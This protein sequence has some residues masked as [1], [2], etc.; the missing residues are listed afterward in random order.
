MT[1]QYYI[2]NMAQHPELQAGVDSLVQ[3]WQEFMLHDPVADAHFGHLY[4][5]FLDYQTAIC[6]MEGQ[7]VARALCVPIFWE[8]G[9]SLPDTGWQWALQNSVDTYTSREAPNTVCAIEISVHPKLRGTGL[10]TIALQ[11]MKELAHAKGFSNLVAPVRPNMK[12]RYPL[13]SMVDYITW[14]HDDSGAP[15]DAWLRVHWRV[16][17][18]MVSVA[19]KSMRITGTIAEWESWT[20]MRFPQSGAHIVSGAL[21]P[22]MMDL[23]ADQGVYVEPNV[24][25]LHTL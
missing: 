23:E 10:S 19:S 22:V 24:W 17:A 7:V 4:D 8:P 18:Q 1:E 5:W 20:Q 6:D 13:I 2:R 9:S 12:H 25:M 3:Y 16:G 15:F 11:A 21:S 14:T